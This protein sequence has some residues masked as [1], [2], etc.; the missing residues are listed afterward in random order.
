MS[1]LP[2][3]PSRDGIVQLL[4]AEKQCRGK[5]TGLLRESKGRFWAVSFSVLLGS[6]L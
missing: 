1:M 3:A 4:T 5:G 6:G 2:K